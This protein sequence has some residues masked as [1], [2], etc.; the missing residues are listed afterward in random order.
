MSNL[1][2]MRNRIAFSKI[3]HRAINSFIGK[4]IT[5]KILK[6]MRDT[7]LKQ[8]KLYFS[9]TSF[10][11]KVKPDPRNKDKIVINIFLQQL[12]DY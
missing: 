12:N 8:C 5:K 2:K 9:P 10:G 1:G 7:I 4:P 3:I 6:D 11:I